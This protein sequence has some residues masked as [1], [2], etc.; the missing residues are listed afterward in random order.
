VGTT[1]LVTIRPRKVR[2]VGFALAPVVVAFSVVL[3]LAL[4]GETGENGGVFQPSDQIAMVGLGLLG[5][6]AILLFTRPKVVADE[7]HIKIQ[8]V[9]GG[10]D[11]PWEVVRAIRFD[12][13]NPCLTLELEDDDVVSVMAVQATDKEYAVRSA[14]LLRA[15]HAAH[16]ERA[17]SDL[18][19]DHSA[20]AG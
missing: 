9:L 6:A 1:E 12:R 15:L 8:N 16:R 11:L 5:A 17:A 4:R 7:Q 10:Y 18:P 2:R 14:R 13:G 20:T 19:E 3:G